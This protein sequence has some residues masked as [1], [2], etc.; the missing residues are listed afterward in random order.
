MHPVHMIYAGQ[1]LPAFVDCNSQA[2]LG[3]ELVSLGLSIESYRKALLC[4]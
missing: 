4:L 3:V 2:Q 1:T